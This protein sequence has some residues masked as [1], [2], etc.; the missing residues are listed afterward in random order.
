MRIL[1]TADWHLGKQL[2]NASFLED[3][4]SA[5]EQFH[6]LLREASIDCV[7]VSGDVF[8]RSVPSADSV[9]LFDETLHLLCSD[10]KKPVIITSG[11]HDSGQRLNFGSRIFSRSSLFLF[12][13]F[14]GERHALTLEDSHGAVS[15]FALPYLE[16]PVVREVLRNPDI[17]SQEEALTAALD[18]LSPPTRTGRCVVIA[19]AFVQ[20][21][22]ASD[23]ERPLSVGGAESVNPGIFAPYTYAALGHLH[24]PQSAGAPHVRYSGSLL[25]YSA[26]EIGHKKSFTLVDIDSRGGVSIE[27]VP[28]APR[29]DF[30]E[31]R[32]TLSALLHPDFN[33]GE[34]GDYFVVTLEDEGAVLDAM[35]RLQEKYPNVL[36]VRKLTLAKPGI[37]S[38][39]EKRRTHRDVLSLF[40]GFAAEVAQFVPTSAHFALLKDVCESSAND[41]EDP[42]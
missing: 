9:A 25:K 15:F 6:A 13:T 27:E 36:E 30:R 41:L 5:L 10:F 4:A 29:R 26:S 23:S 1:H 11:N 12:G 14:D 28:I 38:P 22:L 24:R 7:I 2:H 3:Q 39:G 17:H 37:E 34:P 35:P 40:T 31:L 20:G 16:V 21:G 42:L 19:H 8:D 32:G 18:S 33:A